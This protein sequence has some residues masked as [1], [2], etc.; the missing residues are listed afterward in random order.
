MRRIGIVSVL[1]L[2]LL[3]WGW[4]FAQ[5]ASLD[6]SQTFV[7]SEERFQFQY[8]ADWETIGEAGMPMFSIPIQSQ[9]ISDTGFSMDSSSMSVMVFLDEA[10][11]NTTAT[12]IALEQVEIAAMADMLAAP[13][14]YRITGRAAA[15]VD[16]A[17]EIFN[18]TYIA[19]ELAPDTY[20]ILMLNGSVDQIAAT[21]PIVLEVL[22]TARYQ[23]DAT[24]LKR[25]VL[26]YLLPERYVSTNLGIT[27][28]HP[29]DWIAEDT[30]NYVLLT[31]PNGLSLGLSGYRFFED[32]IPAGTENLAVFEVEEKLVQISEQI[33]NS[34]VSEVTSFELQG[35]STARAVLQDESGGQLGLLTIQ[36][37]E[38]S[39]GR[40]TIIGTPA[41]LAQANQTVLAIAASLQPNP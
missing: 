13:L 2:T 5:E 16:T 3:P 27:F 19:L 38:E 34:V 11:T 14:E 36:F 1:L 31:A 22:N 12:D 18:F 20:L 30:D 29:S 15:Q 25:M 17:N 4:A 39:V 35:R 10:R 23:D 37:D 41:Q 8:P 32:K 6:L 7:D 24:P 9:G 33:P 28:E 21:T 26:E 40:M